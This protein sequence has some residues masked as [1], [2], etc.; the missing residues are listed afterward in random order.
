MRNGDFA[1]TRL[2]AE[3]DACTLIVRAKLQGNSESTAA[4]LA[5]GYR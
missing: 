4:I 1:T 3:I 2:D 5:M